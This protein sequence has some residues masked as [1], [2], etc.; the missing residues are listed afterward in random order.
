MKTLAVQLTDAQHEY[1]KQ[2]AKENCRT[3]SDEVRHALF[4]YYNPKPKKYA[5]PAPRNPKLEFTGGYYEV[6]GYID[7]PYDN[8]LK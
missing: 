6:D 4:E 7:N 8:L 2:V 3:M 5:E 1:I